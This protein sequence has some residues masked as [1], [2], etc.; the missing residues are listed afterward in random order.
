[1]K[2]ALFYLAITMISQS[3]LVSPSVPKEF[4]QNF[5]NSKLPDI[6]SA[7]KQSN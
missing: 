4:W 7:L 6:L 5:R 1:M 3:C 2:L